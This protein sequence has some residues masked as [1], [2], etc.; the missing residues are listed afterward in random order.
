[1]EDDP[2]AFPPPLPSL[3]IQLLYKDTE[4]SNKNNIQGN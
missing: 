4:L 2:F 3:D 1:M